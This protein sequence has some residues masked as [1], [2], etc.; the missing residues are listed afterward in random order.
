VFGEYLDKSHFGD[1]LAVVSL[2]ERPA[3]IGSLVVSD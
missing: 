2:K 1:L 3:R